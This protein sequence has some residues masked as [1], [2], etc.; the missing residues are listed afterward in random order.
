MLRR[1]ANVIYWTCSGIALLIAAGYL[2][3]LLVEGSDRN[4]ALGWIALAAM[5]VIYLFGLAARYI[6]VGTAKDR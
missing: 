5:A 1:L 6:L 2:W 4:D 3:V